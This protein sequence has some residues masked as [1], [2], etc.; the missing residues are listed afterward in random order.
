MHRGILCAAAV[1]AASCFAERGPLTNR[2]VQSGG[3]GG[4]I[5]SY[6]ARAARQPVDWQPWDREAF[7]LAARLDRPI[8]LYIGSDSCR[9]CAEADRSIYTDP[10]IAS[11]I[12]T[13]FV[14]VRVDRDE[15]PDIARR[16]QAAVERMA[17]LRGWPLTVFLTADA[18]PFFGGT[19]FPA[20]DPV[21]GRGLTQ[22][23]PEVAKRYHDQRAILMQQAA[24]VRQL[25]LPGPGA[26]GVLR[27]GVVREEIDGLARELDQVGRAPGVQS[28][29]RVAEAASLLLTAYAQGRDTLALRVAERALAV[30]LDTGAVRGDD[31]DPPRLVR[32]ALAGALAKAWVVTGDV[33]YRESGRAI[34]R[35]LAREADP[36]LYADREAFIMERLMLASATLG[37][38]AIE[39]RARAAIDVLLRRAYAKGWG[40]RHS[41][42][43]AVPLGVSVGLL[44]DQVQVASAC[45]VAHQLT[46]DLRYIETARDLVV[47][48]ERDY[49]DS[50]GGYFDAAQ[51]AAIPGVVNDRTKQVFDDV[52]P[53]ANAVAAA[54]LA[55][56]GAVTGEL[57]YRRRAQATLEAFAGAIR[58]AAPDG[59]RATS[60]LAAAREV[61]GAP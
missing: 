11:L 17:S 58:G 13:L 39:A 2:I 61:V 57:A 46:G 37:E 30:R 38:P 19:Y 6:L 44:Q 12:N 53:G 45:L 8:L 20:D 34:V 4:S 41:L 7:A 5:T 55:R 24:I 33:R 59:L 21:T 42:T 35:E 43:S 14:P 10:Q 29:V 26:R 28:S 16:Y 48:I 9:A 27:G 51:S 56:L 52:L 36:T 22:I 15:R 54:V 50:L 31:D 23:L 32:A 3:S 25:A 60:Y 1:L 47:I 18:S 40:V 49:A